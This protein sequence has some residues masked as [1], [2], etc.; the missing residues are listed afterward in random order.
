[1]SRRILKQQLRSL[2][3]DGK[4]NKQKGKGASG[5]KGEGNK[6]KGK[7]GKGTRKRKL[8]TGRKVVALEAKLQTKALMGELR[9]EKRKKKEQ[10]RKNIEVLKT[11]GTNTHMDTALQALKR[12]RRR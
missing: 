4:G 5:E 11:L 8:R 9:S 12:R 6:S 1:M 3:S 10:A 2:L 7:K